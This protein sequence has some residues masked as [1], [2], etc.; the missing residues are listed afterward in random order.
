MRDEFGAW[1]RG[2]T[3]LSPNYQLRRMPGVIETAIIGAFGTGAQIATIA[4]TTIYVSTVAAYAI[5]TAGTM[6]ALKQLA[7]DVPTPTSPDLSNRLQPDSPKQ[8]IYGRTRVGGAITYIESVDNNSNLLQVICIAGHPVEEI[9]DIY[10]NDTRVAKANVGGGSVLGGNIDHPDWKKDGGI[11]VKVFKG[12]GSNNTSALTTLYSRTDNSGVNSTDFTG[13]DTSFLFTNFEYNKDVFT[14]GIP[15]IN[16]VVKGKK[17]YDPRKD[18]TSD[19]Y[20]SS[21]GVSTHRKTDDT[22]WEYSN[23]PALC[24]LDYLTQE[25]GLNVDYDEID[26]TEWATEADICEEQ[27]TEYSEGQDVWI[28]DRYNLNGV[29]TRDMAPQEI[30]P[31]MLSSCAGSLFYAQGKWVLRVGEYRTPISPV[32]DEGDLRGPMS[33]D[34]KTSRRDL[35]NSVTG[36]VSAEYDFTDPNTTGLIDFIPTDYPMVTSSVLETED[37]GTRNTLELPLPFTTDLL[38]AQRIAKQTLFRTREQIVINARFGLKAFQARVGDNIKLTNSRMGWNEKVFEV[39]SWKFAYGEGA[40]LEVDLTLKENSES[41]YDWNADASVF[42]ANNTTLPRYNYAPQPSFDGTPTTEVIIQEDGTT[43]ASADVAWTVTNSNYVNDY[44]LEWK[45]TTETDYQSIVTTK[46]Y[47][48]IPNVEIGDQYNLRIASRNRLGVISDFSTATVT[49]TG[50]T[51]APATVGA[52]T[53]TAMIQA[54]SLDWAAVTTD[55]NGNDLYDLKGYK[56]YRATTNSQPSQPIAFVAADKYVDG[57]LADSTQYYYWVSAVDHTGN[58]GGASASGS[59]TTLV[60]ASGEDG[61]SVA[62]VQVFQRSSTAPSAPTG[63]SFNFSTT[64]L[65]APSG[66][67]VNVPSGTNPVYVSQAIATVQGATGTDSALTWSTP[68]LLVQNGTDGADGNEGPQGPQ[69]AAGDAGEDG[70]SVYTAIVFN[71]YSSA[72]SAP[73]G[74]SFNFGTNALTAPSGWFVDIPSGSDPIYGTRATFS[75]S[76]DTGTDSSPTWSTPFK[77]AEDGADGL[78]GAVGADGLSTFLASVFKRSSS[79]PSTPSGGS[80]NFGTNTLTAPSG[81]SNTIP[82]GT[83]PVYVSTALASIQ[84]TTGTDSSLGWVAPIKLAENG[85]DGDDGATG[86]QGPQGVQGIDGPAGPTGATGA[87]GA[88]GPQGPQGPAGSNGSNGSNGARYAT[89]R[90]YKAGTSAPS[91]SGF[92]SAVSITWSTGA[93]TSSYN[94]WSTATPT[95]AASS[96]NNLYYIDVVFVDTSGSASS[97]NGSSATSA[98]Q[99]FNFNGLV[100]FTNTSG[101]TD[102]NTALA[103]SSTQIDGGS[104]ITGTLSAD[105]ISIDNVTL[106]TNASGELIIKSGGV[107]TAQVKSNALSDIASTSTSSA[108]LGTSFP[109]TTV[110]STNVSGSY[111]DKFLI[112]ASVNDINHTTS[113]AYVR[114]TVFLNNA[115][116]VYMSEI[117]RG[118]SSTNKGGFCLVGVN[119]L[120]TTGSNIPVDFR[121][122]SSNS[123]SSTSQCFLRVIRLKR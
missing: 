83:D 63:G 6:W 38:Q 68:S 50:D 26:D 46:L 51:T 10:V 93:A 52:V 22:T 8:V 85:A 76:G 42:S 7:P 62:L 33:V 29:F 121:I 84:G 65:T 35:Y 53:A 112:V 44:V 104:I 102:L 60:G 74:G 95:V 73:T 36:K 120:N 37:G 71:R 67:S 78:D 57:G 20:D 32:F 41:A 70:K 118:Y 58:E 109:G 90:Y 100:T 19:A 111:G 54:V 80:Y 107:D 81:W 23:N 16:A 3:F 110:L 94:G 17:V 92:P 9:E 64:T 40:A 122:F 117:G 61:N 103:D 28:N 49:I 77:I 88:T 43:V 96:S 119:T 45:R 66:W 15:T 113:S 39:V 14:N 114:A 25:H 21:L 99:L 47:Y 97:S 31:A 105:A 116:Q 69:G 89:V 11:F 2:T 56:I 27:V 30:I 5:Y 115:S 1:A 91:T 101:S 72:P 55:E 87:T 79:A 82:S 75:I 59:V 24:I 106:D 13:N 108:S 86:P 34:T 18:S 12:N 48:R 123:G 4:G 98:T